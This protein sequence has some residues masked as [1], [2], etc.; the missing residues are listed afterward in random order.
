MSARVCVCVCTSSLYL[1]TTALLPLALSLIHAHSPPFHLITSLDT[2]SHAITC[3]P[4]P[5]FFFLQGEEHDEERLRAYQLSRLKYY[6]AVV[7]CDS[8][9]TANAIYDACDGMEY[10]ASSNIVDLR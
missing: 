2:T 5:L 3:H 6:Y 7:T 10:G 4:F 8:A 9:A 1:Q